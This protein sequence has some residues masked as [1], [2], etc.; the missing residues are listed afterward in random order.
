MVG[1]FSRLY[2]RLINS[3]LEARLRQSLHPQ[4]RLWE[5]ARDEACKYIL[6][7]MPNA[8]SFPDWKA[9]HLFCLEKAKQPGLYL[10]FGVAYGGSIN[11][12][13][14]HSER[15]IH[16]FD[17][18]EGLPEDWSGRHEAKGAY[19]LQGQL[20]EVEANVR[21]YK[22][23]FEETLPGFLVQNTEPAALIH[24]DCDLYSST[25][26]LLTQLEK[27]IRAGT[28][29]IFDEYFN[30]ISWRQH[31]FKAFQEFVQRNSID[32]E[33]IGWSY[34]QVAVRILRVANIPQL[35]R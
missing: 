29:I 8:L 31:E 4:T 26:Y 6:E 12:L 3:Y 15:T 33:Y 20:P 24:I 30:F 16:G 28:I 22:G 9:L 10:E 7:R 35:E 5:M 25:Q 21:L 23:W 1:S 2:H 19:S 13:A 34:Q 11:W 27:R 14:R 17:S 32:Y 18:F